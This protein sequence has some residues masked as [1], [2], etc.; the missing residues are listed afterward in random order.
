MIKRWKDNDILIMKSMINE[1]TSPEIA[2]IF[3]T[4][5]KAINSLFTRRKIIRNKEISKE[6][7]RKSLIKRNKK[8]YGDK[9]GNWKGGI[10][11]N[12]YHYKKLQIEKFPERE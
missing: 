7:V 3:E 2:E 12:N 10:S 4:S 8:N 5:T 11:K 6:H 9:N 1:K